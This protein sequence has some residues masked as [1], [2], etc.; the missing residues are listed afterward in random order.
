MQSHSTYTPSK[1]GRYLVTDLALASP[2]GLVK[3]PTLQ[4]PIAGISKSP[5]TVTSSLNATSNT[6]LLP[7]T[8]ISLF[9][10]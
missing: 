9:H 3:S 6:S 2:L 1:S 5:F 7:G 10:I 8:S 4:Y